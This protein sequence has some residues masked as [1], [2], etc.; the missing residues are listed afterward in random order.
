VKSPVHKESLATAKPTEASRT[1][2]SPR[3]DD[4]PAIATDDAQWK[5]MIRCPAPPR[6]PSDLP[7]FG[8]VADCA[9]RRAASST[10]SPVLPALVA[11]W[12]RRHGPSRVAPGRPWPRGSWPGGTRAGPA[13]PAHHHRGCPH[14]GRRPP[15]RR[16]APRRASS[17]RPLLAAWPRMRLALWRDAFALTLVPS[18]ATRPIL[19]MP[20]ARHSVS[21]SVNSAS[22][23]AR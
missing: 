21:A 15:R 2:R 13:P 23:A 7:A 6:L 8:W 9:A 5:G 17:P 18:R 22:S 4:V 11:F 10:S 3:H 12:R 19:T 1:G 20:D 14:R 16:R